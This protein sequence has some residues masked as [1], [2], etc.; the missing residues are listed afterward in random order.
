LM[1]K[2]GNLKRKGMDR[3]G[4]NYPDHRSGDGEKNWERADLSFGDHSIGYGGLKAEIARKREGSFSVIQFPGEQRVHLDIKSQ[5]A[6][7]Q[8]KGKYEN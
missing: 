3:P 7:L 1:F 8:G 2:S 6:S 4:V 5:S